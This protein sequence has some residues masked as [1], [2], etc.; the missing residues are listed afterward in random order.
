MTPEELLRQG[1]LDECLKAVEAQ[2]RANPAEAKLRVMLFQ[3]LSVM[4]QWDRAQ[5]QLQTCAQMN[6]GNMLM[7]Q[8]CKQAIL[9]EHLRNEVWSGKRTP[10][11]LGEPEEWVSWVIQA[12]GM[13]ANGQHDAAAELR[14]R[15]FDAAPAV[16]GA[17][18]IGDDAAPT[19]FEWIADADERLG[20]MLEAIVDGKYYWIP[21]QRIA[22]VKIDKPTDLRDTVWLPATFIWSAGG[23]SVGLIPVRYPGSEQPTNDPL[24]RMARKTEFVERGGVQVPLGQRL[25]ATDTGEY[26]LL[27]VRVVR[28][29]DA[30]LNPEA[31]VAGANTAGLAMDSSLKPGAGHG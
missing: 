6:P 28:V 7:A 19:P 22:Q 13:S 14:G 20:P 31:A 21:W 2:V 10:L 12:A 15:A 26:S 25:L 24:I 17:I 8:V 18:T 23:S 29:G 1:K 16:A 30:P 9:C 3:V 5:T 11:V 4:G 27:E